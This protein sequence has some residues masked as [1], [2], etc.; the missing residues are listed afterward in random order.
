MCC[1]PPPPSLSAMPLSDSVCSIQ[2]A[3]QPFKAYLTPRKEVTL[4]DQWANLWKALRSDSHPSPHETKKNRNNIS[5]SLQHLD[6]VLTPEEISSILIGE[7][8]GEN[9]LPQAPSVPYTKTLHLLL[10]IPEHLVRYL[11]D[12]DIPFSL[13]RKKFYQ[14][15]TMTFW[16]QFAREA[17]AS[18]KAQEFCTIILCRGG[19]E[20]LTHA[21]VELIMTLS[22]STMGCFCHVL[23]Q[24][25]IEPS[26][27]AEIKPTLRLRRFSF[28]FDVPRYGKTFLEPPELGSKT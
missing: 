24:L 26:I 25:V 4:L 19:G 3:S 5:L 17:I 9:L 11:N 12:E 20:M 15:V 21:A 23:L 16:S 28:R 10:S 7:P 27:K 13:Q 2:T 14:L 6:E 1:L 18:K 8:E 22:D